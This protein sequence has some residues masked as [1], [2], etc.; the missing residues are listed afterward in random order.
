MVRTVCMCY[1]VIFS[2]PVAY[3]LSLGLSTRAGV[4][5]AV[6]RA[7]IE[8]FVQ[9]TLNGKMG[10]KRAVKMETAEPGQGSREETNAGHSWLR[11]IWASFR[12]A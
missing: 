1:N 5:Q 4:T 12:P 10:R 3:R 2:S 11:R 9:L 7:Q 8:P 6:A